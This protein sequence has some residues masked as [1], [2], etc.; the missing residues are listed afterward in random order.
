MSTASITAADGT[1]VQ[2]RPRS[3]PLLLLPV[4]SVVGLGTTGYLTY[5][6]LIHADPACSLVR[7]C[8]TVASSPY[9]SIGAIPV[10]T[11]G[12]AL[13]A[14]ILVLGVLVLRGPFAFRP[15][16]LLGIFG[17]TLFGTLYSGYLTYIEL[18]VLQAIC[19]WCLT[20]AAVVTVMF[21][22][23]LFVLLRPPGAPAD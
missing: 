15:W 6:R 18:F 9:A 2:E 8:E 4:L 12:F 16:A 14:S 3:L 19:Q 7:G 11:L 20:S 22:L 5:V 10:A 23:S 1:N 17:L 13:Y 21:G